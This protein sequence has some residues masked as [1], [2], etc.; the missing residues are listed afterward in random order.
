MALIGDGDSLWASGNQVC[1]GASPAFVAIPMKTNANAY[2]AMSG[3]I[4]SGLIAR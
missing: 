3:F 4:I 2:F 1:M